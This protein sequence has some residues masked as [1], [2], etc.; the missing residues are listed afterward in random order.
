MPA[1]RQENI[2]EARDQEVGKA[3]VSLT[4]SESMNTES[5]KA[6]REEK[7]S[8]E[9][10]QPPLEDEFPDGG[11]QAWLAVLGS[12]I[13]QFV[14]FG[15]INSFGVYQDYY[16]RQYL[17]GSSPSDIGWIGGVQIFLNFSLGIITGPAFDRGYF[18]HLIISGTVLHALALFM[19]S[20]SHKNSYYQVFLTN[21]LA[22]GLSS[23]I[24]YIPTLGLPT[25]YFKRR[26]PLVLGLTSSGA[27]MGA[28]IHPLLLNKLFKG[29]IGFHNG[30]RISGAINVTLLIIA[31]AI[32]RTRLPPKPI[33]HHSPIKSW[34]KEPAY[35]TAVI[36][37]WFIFLGL[38]YPVFYLQLAAIQNGVNPKFATYALS[39]LNASSFLGRIIPGAFAPSLGLFNLI[40]FFII[41]SGV[42]VLCMTLI[43]DV[44]GTVFIAISFGFFSGAAISLT[45]SIMAVLSKN[46]HEFGARMGIV[47]LFAGLLGLFATPIA[48]ALLTKQYKWINA[49]L[50]SGISLIIAG[51]CFAVVRA[52]VLRQRGAQ[53]SGR[54]INRI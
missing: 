9:E 20:L 17:T 30:V 35:V 14:T 28:V 43:R 25:H 21:G 15:Y 2:H 10:I 45:P 54:L 4:Q 33:L 44:V 46:M 48:G 42:V 31:C 39:I 27:A 41:S 52:L 13:F 7:V 12:F 36:A 11:R 40:V 1:P 50:F 24:S 34:L 38:F 32:M 53:S 29:S 3:T 49:G 37:G 8:A 22:L 5:E 47:F 23:G 26:R 6:K 18:Y 19:L 16:A 51:A